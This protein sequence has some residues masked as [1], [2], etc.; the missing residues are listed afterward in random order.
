MIENSGFGAA[1]AGPAA[2]GIYEA[3]LAKKGGGIVNQE[4]AKK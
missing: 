2:K 3:Y 1:N 4:V